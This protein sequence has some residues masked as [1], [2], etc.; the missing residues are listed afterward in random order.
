MG[1]VADTLLIFLAT[2][3]IHREPGTARC[4]RVQACAAPTVLGY[5]FLRPKGC[6]CM[7]HA[8]IGT[9]GMEMHPHVTVRMC[10]NHTRMN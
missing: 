2:C 7:D 4:S 6:T 3:C 10:S 5:I 8:Y 9:V 1:M